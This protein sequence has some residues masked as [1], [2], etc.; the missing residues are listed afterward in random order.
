MVN[1]E[2]QVTKT[3]INKS[4]EEL[5]KDI[6]KPMELYGHI[7]LQAIIDKDGNINVIECNPRF[8][9]A[10]A[11]SIKSGLDSFYWLYLE[12]RGLNIDNYPF[13]KLDHEIKQVRSQSDIYL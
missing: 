2:S 13:K 10:S 12:S 8:G 7:I 1:G 3:I 5:F 4:L 6:I 11:I 9:G